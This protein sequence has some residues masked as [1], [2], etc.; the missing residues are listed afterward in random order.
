MKAAFRSFAVGFALTLAAAG[1][2]VQ[3]QGLG[4]HDTRAPVTF[5]ADRIQVQDREDRIILSGGVDISQAGLNLRAGRTLI[6]Y[7]DAGELE[8]QRITAT[9]GVTV[10]RGNETARGEVAIYDFNRRIIT[11]TGDVRLRRGGDSLNGQRL[12][13]DLES[14]LSSIDGR[15]GGEAGTAS[16]GSGRVTGTFTVP[17]D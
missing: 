14:G 11:L 2:I 1:M 13:I 17:Q 8:I 16:P 6:N 15:I 4:S 5:A 12:T 10:S 7:T 9:G 3:A